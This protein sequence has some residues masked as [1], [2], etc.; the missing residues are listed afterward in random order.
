MEANLQQMFDKLKKRYF[1]Q[2]ITKMNFT[3]S[4][5]IANVISD[6]S[7]FKIFD[8]DSVVLV[9]ATAMVRPRIQLV[10]VLL[11][12]L[13]HI[14]LRVCS[15]NAI[16]INHHDENFRKIMCFL[17]SEIKSEIS[18]SLWTDDE[19]FSFLTDFFYVDI[20]QVPQDARRRRLPKPLVSVHRHLPDLRA[21]P[22]HSSLHN[23]A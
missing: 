13:I 7:C 17:N 16:R 1:S 19:S 9:K 2:W 15:K 11:H 4:W 18:V 12:I 8:L 21:L 10:S 14:Y 5:D 23:K 22:W 3:V 20:S 6:D